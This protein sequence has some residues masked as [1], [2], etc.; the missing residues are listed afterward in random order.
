M[1]NTKIPRI[2]PAKRLLYALVGLLAG[3]LIL[4]FFLLQHAL[5]ATILAG[6]PARTLPDA[7]RDLH[8]LCDLLARR[9]DARRPARNPAVPCTLDHTPVLAASLD[10][11]RWFWPDRVACD[12]RAAQSKSHL[13]PQLRRNKHTLRLHNPGFDRFFHGL[14]GL[15]AQGNEEQP[16]PVTT[17]LPSSIVGLS[18]HLLK[19]SAQRGDGSRRSDSH[20]CQ[21]GR[22]QSSE[23]CP[24]QRRRPGAA[25][26]LCWTVCRWQSPRQRPESVSVLPRSSP[27]RW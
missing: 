24:F 14:P 21:P 17:L 6:E 4:L 18:A 3:D 10:C 19:A 20:D 1:K 5:H 9:L 23:I 7:V 11:G 15:A 26:E 22:R 12:L 8:P 27:S 25:S 2:S 13:L 16:S